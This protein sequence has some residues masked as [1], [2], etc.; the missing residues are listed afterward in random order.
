MRL[1]TIPSKGQD[2]PDNDGHALNDAPIDPHDSNNDNDNIKIY[3]KPSVSFD[4]STKQGS[5]DEKVVHHDDDN[6]G[7]DDDVDDDYDDGADDT[8]AHR[9][10]ARLHGS[11]SAPAVPENPTEL[12]PPIVPISLSRPRKSDPPPNRSLKYNLRQHPIPSKKYQ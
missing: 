11:P 1:I 6:D 8:T 12:T 7:D 3:V 10:S 2:D 4:P 5:V 9:P